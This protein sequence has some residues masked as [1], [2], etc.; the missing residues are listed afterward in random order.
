MTD[1]GI[2]NILNKTP[3]FSGLKE[4]ELRKM[5]SECRL[6][7]WDKSADIDN[8]EG[9]DIFNIIVE[10]RIKL[11]QTDPHS[12]RSIAIFLLE[13]GDVFDVLS[14]LDGRKHLCTPV[15][16]SETYML[17]VPMATA[18]E[19]LETYPEF[20]ERFLPYVG[21]LMRRL[22]SFAETVVFDDTATRLAKLILQ[23]T[24]KGK[25]D[26]ENN[27][28]VKMINN[29]THE[30]LA[31][32]IGSVRS[33]VTAQLRKLKEDEIILYKRGY[34]AVKKLEEL[35]ERYNL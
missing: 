21:Q 27:Y 20:N 25:L 8:D 32:M 23:H 34:F 13:R 9:I 3:L 26:E 5:I 15:A 28:P 12:G 16:V 4:E 19:W 33:V 11:M 31:E 35:I 17:R 24:E 2:Y 10:G 18:R 22:E 1:D 29:V 30:L 7:R 6:T 14:L